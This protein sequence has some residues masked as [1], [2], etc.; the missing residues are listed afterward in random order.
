MP[1]AMVRRRLSRRA[2]HATAHRALQTAQP[3]A[4]LV[5]GKHVVQ[6]QHGRRV[7]DW[8]KKLRTL[9]AHGWVGLEGVTRS[10]NR[11]SSARSSRI[12]P[13]YSASEDHGTIEH[14]VGVS[15]SA[16][17][18]RRSWIASA[19]THVRVLRASSQ[20]GWLFRLGPR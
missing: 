1:S 16:I 19:P 11:C 2:P 18:L 17:W 6:R 5:G 14:V 20:T 9:S 13:S 3:R 7:L 10:G 12:K 4:Q 15:C 8:R